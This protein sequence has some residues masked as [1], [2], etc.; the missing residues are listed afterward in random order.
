M[1]KL[2]P[3]AKT[4]RRNTMLRHAQNVSAAQNQCCIMQMVNALHG[5]DIWFDSFSQR[6]LKEEKKAKVNAKAAE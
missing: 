3:Y 1:I 2:N 6:K 4:L 5:P